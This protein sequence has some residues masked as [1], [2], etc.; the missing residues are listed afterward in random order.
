M[1]VSHLAVHVGGVN[2]RINIVINIIPSA[3]FCL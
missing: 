2:S 1:H 3:V